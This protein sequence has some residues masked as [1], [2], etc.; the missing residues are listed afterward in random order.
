MQFDENE[1]EPMVSPDTQNSTKFNPEDAPEGSR[2]DGSEYYNQF[3]SVLRLINRGTHTRAGNYLNDTWN[4]NEHKRTTDNLAIYDAIAGQ[5]DL[6]RGLKSWARNLFKQLDFR[7]FSQP[8][9]SG[10]GVALAAFCACSYVCW[11][12]GGQTHPNHSD[13]NAHFR[14]I[15]DKLGASNDQFETWYGRFQNK[16]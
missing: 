6:P 11:K 5:L 7:E 14:K 8:N 4:D 10:N 13:R 15:Q 9:D 12:Q 3:Y 1:A 16:I 2:M